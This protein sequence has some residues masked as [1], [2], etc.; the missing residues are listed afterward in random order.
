MKVVVIGGGSTYTPELVNG[1]LARV[2]SFPLRELCL[3]DVDQS[4]LEIVGGF[5]RRLAAAKGT[6]FDIQLAL[7]RREALRGAA[8]VITQFRV[9]GMA[10]RRADEYLGQRHGLIGQ[11]TT[12]VGGLAKALRTIPVVLE[13]AAQMQELAPTA[14]LV[15]FT[16]PAGLITEALQRYAPDVASVGV[17]NVP[18]TATMGFLDILAQQLGTPLPAERAELRTL[19]LNHLTWHRGLTLDGEELWPRLL[20]GYLAELKADPHPEWGVD[21]IESWE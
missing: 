8:Y 11:E 14:L 16:N 9:G 4:R 12:G 1:F 19:G 20:E 18:I 5:A 3:M 13:L 17:C 7:D 2:A 6:P 21:L 10:A 15:N